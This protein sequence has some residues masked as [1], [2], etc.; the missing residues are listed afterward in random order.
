MD[1]VIVCPR[2][3]PP[4][5]GGKEVTPY[6]SLYGEAP[7]QRNTFFSLQVYEMLGISLA[8]VYECVGKY[9]ISSVKR[10]KRSIMCILRADV[11]KYRP[12]VCKSENSKILKKIH[13]VALGKL[14]T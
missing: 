7:P 9:V 1:L 13:K 5:G 4:R 2:P 12:E 6:N 14:L 3:P 10:L 11:S 8:E